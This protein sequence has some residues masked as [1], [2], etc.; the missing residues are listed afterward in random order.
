MLTKTQGIVL[1]SIPYN[2]K[3][4]IIYMYTRVFG[5]ASYLVPRSRGKRSF[6]SKA[7]FLPLSVLDLEVD[8]QNKRDLHRIRE[9]KSCFPQGELFSNPIKN[10]LALFLAEVLFRVVREA[11]P[12]ERL[13]DYLVQSIRLL[14]VADAGIANFH[15]VF[16]LGLLR[17]LGIFPNVES[18]ARDAF[19]DLLLGEFVERQ[20]THPHFLNR[21][22]SRVFAGL[23]RI[24]YENM[25]L[26]AFSRQ[27]RVAIIQHI[28]DYYRLH[29]PDFPEI[30]SLSVM[31]SLFD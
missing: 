24:N 26:Y 13:F 5:R 8:H 18:V 19:F 27:D 14:E 2:D 30:K 17:Y 6:V 23:L 15:L 12:D 22:E 9:S 3:Y 1:H 29:L 31:Q 28:I 7:L 21:N 25:S 10:V 4:A 11:Q 20:P 16:L